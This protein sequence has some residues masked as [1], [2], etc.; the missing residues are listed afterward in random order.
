MLVRRE[1]LAA[2]PGVAIAVALVPPLCS[3][4]ILLYYGERELVWN[5]ALLFLTN[6][7]AIVLAASAMSLF[8]RVRPKSKNES[9][10]RSLGKKAAAHADRRVSLR[11]LTSR[12]GMSRFHQGSSRLRVSVKTQV[13]RL[14]PG[15][16]Q[17]TR[18]VGCGAEHRPS[19]PAGPRAPRAARR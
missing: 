10:N 12:L 15:A 1:S 18:L 17:A 16:D 8:M 7:S 19:V 3:A 4:G 2:L 11:E 9:L 14:L 5:A 13:A 6:A